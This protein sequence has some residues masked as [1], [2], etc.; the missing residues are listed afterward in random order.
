MT[1]SPLT[2]VKLSVVPLAADLR[3]PL[4]PLLAPTIN[5]PSIAVRELFTTRVVNV[6]ISHKKHSY[7]LASLEYAAASNL[8]SYTL[9]TPIWLPAP[10][11]WL[12]AHLWSL[13]S[14]TVLLP[15]PTEAAPKTRFNFI[16][17]HLSKANR[18]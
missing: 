1:N 11:V 14:I 15:K 17:E 8:K 7:T 5:D 13:N 4:A 16:L 6:W 2:D 10:L 3:Y 9:A 12:A 18:L